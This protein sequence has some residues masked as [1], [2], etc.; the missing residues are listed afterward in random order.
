MKGLCIIWLMCLSGP[1]LAQGTKPAAAAAKPATPAVKPAAVKPDTSK[2]AAPKDTLKTK[3][4]LPLELG[5]AVREENTTGINFTLPYSGMVELKLID[6]D[7]KVAFTDQYIGKIG[8][9]TLR[10]KNSGFKKTGRYTYYLW[11]KGKEIQ[12]FIDN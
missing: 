7:G 5:E 1:V 9:N 10:L 11:F 12:G 3:P 4:L 8:P 6:P 2:K